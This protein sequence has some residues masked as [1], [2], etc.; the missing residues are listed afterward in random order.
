MMAIDFFSFYIV[1][2]Q[3]M[4]VD[5]L[6]LST[7]Y[8][9]G[10]GGPLSPHKFTVSAWTYDAVKAVVAADKITDTK[11]GKLQVSSGFFLCTTF[12]HF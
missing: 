5:R 8:F 7:V 9:T 4:Y 11:Y 10:I 2:H 6:D 12:F 1:V 3:L